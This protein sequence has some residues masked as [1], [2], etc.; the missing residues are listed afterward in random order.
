MEWNDIIKGFI[1]LLGVSL[2][3]TIVILIC[4]GFI[5]FVFYLADKINIWRERRKRQY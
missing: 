1:V 4:A 2:A 5:H 3:A